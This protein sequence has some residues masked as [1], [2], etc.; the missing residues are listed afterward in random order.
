MAAAQ[1]LGLDDAWFG[2]PGPPPARSRWTSGTRPSSAT[3]PSLPAGDTTLTISR[4]D[5]GDLDWYPRRRHRPAQPAG[6]AEAPVRITPGRL[7][8]PSAPL[9]RWWQI[10]DAQVTIGGQAPDRAALATLLLIDLVVNHSDDWYTFSLPA[11]AGQIITLDTV[12]VTDSFGDNWPLT[13]PKDWSLFSTTGLDPS[14]MRH[15]GHRAHPAGRSR[16]RSGR[17]RHRR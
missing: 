2:Q 11:A 16:P 8:Y 14:S 3:P 6:A 5:G 13:V 15:L 9:P 10:E 1:R 17:H 4:H 7:R 12:T